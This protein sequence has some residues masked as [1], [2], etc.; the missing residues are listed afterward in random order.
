[1][2]EVEMVAKLTMNETL[3]FGFCLY[4][5]DHMEEGEMVAELTIN[6][7]PHLVLVCSQMTIMEEGE[8]VPELIII[9]DG[10]IQGAR[11]ASNAAQ[12]QLEGRGRGS[13][14]LADL[15]SGALMVGGACLEAACLEAEKREGEGEGE[16]K[17]LENKALTHGWCQRC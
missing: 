6:K 9:A 5:G 2:E 8:M 10:E 1:M 13:T 11:A 12:S 3:P 16:R 4:A 17:G 7:T 15:G 14:D